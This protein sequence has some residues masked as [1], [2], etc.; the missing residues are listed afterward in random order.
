MRVLI[1]ALPDLV[2]TVLAT[3]SLIQFLLAVGAAYVA[4][5]LRGTF[6]GGIFENPWKIVGMSPLVYAAGQAIELME[7]TFF[8]TPLTETLGS[9]VEVAFILILVYGLFRFASAW[10]PSRKTLQEK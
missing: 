5:T 2:D 8:D 9:L 1:G 7:S 3:F 4:F 10:K 6:Q